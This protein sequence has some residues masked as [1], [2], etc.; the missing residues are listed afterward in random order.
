MAATI[1]N[2]RIA[3]ALAREER[4]WVVAEME[5]RE[6]RM[7][8]KGRY[9]RSDLADR[10]LDAN[11]VHSYEQSN[12]LRPVSNVTYQVLIW[13]DIDPTALDEQSMTMMTS[14]EVRIVRMTRPPAPKMR[15]TDRMT[16]D[17][18]I[19]IAASEAATHASICKPGGCTC[20]N[21]NE[22]QRLRS[23]AT[24]L[25]DKGYSDALG[26][27]WH[28][29]LDEMTGGEPQPRFT[30]SQPR[31]RDVGMVQKTVLINTP[32]TEGRSWVQKRFGVL[33]V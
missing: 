13:P 24:E 30:Q 29:A 3:A 31:P 18:W 33:D 22:Y 7:G 4:P 8:D 26:A 6:R 10:M 2:D 25:F 14:A 28:I 32:S 20:P 21:C 11:E 1:F 9:Y 27:A 15:R 16:A 17:Q 23:R 5:R 12:M 19:R